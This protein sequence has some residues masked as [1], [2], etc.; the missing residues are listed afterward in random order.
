[1]IDQTPAFLAHL[2]LGA[3]VLALIFAGRRIVADALACPAFMATL[4][5]FRREH[6]LPTLGCFSVCVVTVWFVLVT[7]PH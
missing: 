5:L 2:A 4:R 7:L 1:M 3:V 6:V